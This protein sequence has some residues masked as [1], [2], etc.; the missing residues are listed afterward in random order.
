MYCLPTKTDSRNIVFTSQNKFKQYLPVKI[1]N[2]DNIILLLIKVNVN[3]IV[4]FSSQNSNSNSLVLFTSQNKLLSKQWIPIDLYS[5]F[6]KTVNSDSL[7]TVYLL[8]FC[9]NKTF[10]SCTVYLS[11]QFLVKTEILTVLYCLFV[12]IVIQRVLYCLFVETNS[13]QN[14]NS[15]NFVLFIC[16]N[17]NLNSHVLFICQN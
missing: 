17:I 6:V 4:L 10:H 1:V 7:C 16:Q 13:S 3:S 11:E 8:N 9:Q 12:K 2:P 14:S 5:L 15:N